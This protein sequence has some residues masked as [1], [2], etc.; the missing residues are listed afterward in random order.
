MGQSK[1]PRVLLQSTAPRTKRISSR[2]RKRGEGT[3]VT[4]R[5]FQKITQANGSFRFAAVV[6]PD[7]KIRT[8][9][10]T[11][12]NN[13]HKCINVS[14][15]LEKIAPETEIAENEKYQS[16]GCALFE[17]NRGKTL[18]DANGATSDY[19]LRSPSSAYGSIQ[20]L[21]P[22]VYTWIDSSNRDEIHL[23]CS[24]L[25]SSSDNN[26]KPCDTCSK[27]L[28]KD[29]FRHFRD[30]PVFREKLDFYS[31]NSNRTGSSDHA[32]GNNRHSSC[33]E[34]VGRWAEE[35][36]L[37]HLCPN[38]CFLRA[39]APSRDWMVLRKN[40]KKVTPIGE[41]L[42]DWTCRLVHETEANGDENLVSN[43]ALLTR[44]NCSEIEEVK[45]N[46]NVK[47]SLRGRLPRTIF[48]SLKTGEVCGPL[49]I[50]IV[51]II[52]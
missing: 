4:S 3:P 14:R 43:R 40:L 8:K 18:V 49:F 52:F 9:R 41:I 16:L 1:A 24:R 21:G 42:K 35:H 51:R 31:W 36:A 34:V 39:F 12:N 46:L 5:Y 47:H 11:A 22:L 26:G 15:S 17:E 19:F 50:F 13:T 28:M 29:A 20:S 37:R 33:V 32:G 6:S 38:Q 2:K 23:N 45:K 27:I 10:A 48:V 30:C 25:T 7:S 44:I